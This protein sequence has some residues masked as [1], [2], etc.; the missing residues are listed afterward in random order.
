MLFFYLTNSLHFSPLTSFSALGGRCW[1]TCC[2][3]L[4][5]HI[6]CLE[7]LPV[8][9]SRY[10]INTRTC[11]TKERSKHSVFLLHLLYIPSLLPSCF[12]TISHSP[13]RS[14]EVWKSLWSLQP[15]LPADSLPHHLWLLCLLCCS[16]FKV[17][18]PSFLGVSPNHSRSAILKLLWHLLA[19]LLFR[20]YFELHGV[21]PVSCKGP[22]D[23]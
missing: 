4:S 10:S 8:L 9:R 13:H 18:S 22:S 20:I 14:P 5:P 11:Q 16:P 23:K 19:I 15:H 7:L 6:L 2:L 12:A 17:S 21:I 3:L 1:N